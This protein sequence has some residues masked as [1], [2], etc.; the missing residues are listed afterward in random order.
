MTPEA[1]AELA[2]LLYGRG[3]STSSGGNLSARSGEGFFVSG[4]GTAFARQQPGDFARCDLAGAHLDGPAPSKEAGFHAALYRL[5]P[6]VNVVLHVHA[7]A[8]LGLSCLAEPTSGNALPILSSYAVTQVGRVPL[9]PYFP[10]GSKELVEAVEAACPDVNALLLQNHGTLVW[11][12][13]PELAL[14]RL[15]ELEQ[16]ARVWLLTH[17]QARVLSD[18]ELLVA[19]RTARHRAQVAAGEQRPRLREGVKGWQP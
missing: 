11:A 3:H 1:L 5:K 8:S 16:N 2:R 4:T 15:E 19:N 18:T 7:D 9:L 10:P 6:E 12:E 17:G 13:T 14:D